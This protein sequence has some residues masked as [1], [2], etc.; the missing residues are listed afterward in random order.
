MADATGSVKALQVAALARL[1]RERERRALQELVALRQREAEAERTREAADRNF[2]TAENGRRTSEDHIYRSLR[3]AGPLPPAGIERHR[4]AIGRLT[5]CVDEAA[6]HLD[7][8]TATLRDAK[9]AVEAGRIRLIARTRD[10][11]KWSQ[12][13]TRIQ[14]ADLALLQMVTERESEDDA[15]LRYGR[16]S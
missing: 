13:E 14:D 15:E 8:A 4:E 3:K 5:V 16:K 12:I 9:H 11:R 10:S 2:E 6:H 7:T 1:R